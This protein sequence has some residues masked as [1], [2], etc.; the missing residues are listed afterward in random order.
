MTSTQTCIHIKMTHID[1]YT[2][3]DTHT[4]I[5]TQVTHTADTHKDG[6]H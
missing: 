6:T 4:D 5:H 2:Y 1:M 3:I